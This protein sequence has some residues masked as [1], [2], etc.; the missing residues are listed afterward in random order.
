M[1]RTNGVR[2]RKLEAIDER[3]LAGL[4]EVLVDCVEGGDSVSFMLPMSAAK[5]EA[6]WR[7][8]GASLARGERVVLVAEDGDSA[9][10]GTVTVVW[11][12][13]ENQPHRADVAKMLVHRR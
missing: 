5:A 12:Q 3:E 9:V 11:A 2:I 8:A 1:A 7:A 13:P 4:C 6:F 10:V